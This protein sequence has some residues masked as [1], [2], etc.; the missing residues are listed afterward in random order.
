MPTI[1]VSQK[2]LELLEN[3][4]KRYAKRL[5]AESGNVDFFTYN[6]LIQDALTTLSE[7][8]SE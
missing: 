7:I 8:Q 6:F 5:L 4:R 1:E 3:W 2:T